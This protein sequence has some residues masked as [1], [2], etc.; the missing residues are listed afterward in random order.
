MDIKQSI[1]N[2]TAWIKKNPWLA[3]GI[4]VV[5][6]LI[7]YAVSK[8]KGSGSVP[9]LGEEEEESSGFGSGSGSLGGGLIESIDS[10]SGGVTQ[11]PPQF[12]AP[13]FDSLPRV[14]ALQDEGYFSPG[15]PLQ[16]A[17]YQAPTMSN[18]AVM[19]QESGLMPSPPFRPAVAAVPAA[20]AKSSNVQLMAAGVPSTV[21]DYVSS[22]NKPGKGKK[23]DNKQTPA[24]KVGKGRNFTG[25]YLGIYYVLGYPA[26]GSAKAPANPAVKSA[27]VNSSN[28]QLM[29]AGVP[30][31]VAGYISGNKKNKKKKK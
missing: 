6:I 26:S 22:Q 9:T 4:L 20:T 7:A 19:A 15:A 27:G 31:T 30:S 12:S 1:S 23:S 14:N 8:M 11:A 24:Q 25:S 29:A 3:G 16:E 13:I 5:L 10:A 21:A 18:N 2:V 17:F 28:T